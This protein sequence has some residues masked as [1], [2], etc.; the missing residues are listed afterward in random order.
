MADTDADIYSQLVI[1][2]AELFEDALG[3]NSYTANIMNWYNHS[4]PFGKS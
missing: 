4:G 2:I 1:E 3:A